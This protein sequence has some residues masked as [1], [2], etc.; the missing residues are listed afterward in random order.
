MQPVVVFSAFL[1]NQ[2][3]QIGSKCIGKELG[4]PQWPE[5]PPGFEEAPENIK[6]PITKP[7][8]DKSVL[9][10]VKGHP[11]MPTSPSINFTKWA[12][13]R[14]LLQIQRRIVPHFKAQITSVKKSHNAL[15]CT[16]LFGRRIHPKSVKQ[17]E[18]KG[19]FVFHY[20]CTNCG[21][22]LECL[23]HPASTSQN[24]P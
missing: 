4:W 3:L 6:V 13:T 23:L 11:G 20:T 19:N 16:N 17:T 24:G 7:E 5:L 21:G 9:R 14:K 18:R 2:Q 10:C 8:N 12:L 15:L 1:R 22:I